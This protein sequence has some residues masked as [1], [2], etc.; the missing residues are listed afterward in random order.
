[1]SVSGPPLPPTPG[2]TSRSLDP[3][4][5]DLWKFFEDRGAKLKE[6][7]FATVTWIVGLASL[8]L[9]F[10]VKEG[11]EAGS[12]FTSTAHPHIRHQS[13]H[14]RTDSSPLRGHCRQRLWRAHQPHFQPVRCRTSGRIVPPK[15]LGR[16]RNGDGERAAGNLS[17]IADGPLLVRLWIPNPDRHRAGCPGHLDAITGSSVVLG[18]REVFGRPPSR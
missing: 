2:G 10:A 3:I 9:G 18:E 5:V 17:A 1:V 8:V 12:A 16:R 14:R 13:E 6:S 11:F 7:M 4:S 15:G